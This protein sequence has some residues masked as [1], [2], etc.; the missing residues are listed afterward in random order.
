M[1]PN[2]DYF[3]QLKKHNPQL[4]QYYMRGIEIV[5]CLVAKTYQAF[6]VGGAVRD[7]L[8]NKE[9]KDIDIATS[10]T[11]KEL[12]EIF[13][14]AGTRYSEFGCI[15]INENGM[16]FQITTFR[17]EELVLTRQTKDIHYSKQLIDDVLR[18]DFTVNALALSANRNIVDILKGQKDIENKKV[19][20]IGDGKKRFKEDP[21]RILRGIE[22]ISRYNFSL[23]TSTSRAMKS[24]HKEIPNI[25]EQKLSELLW[26]ILNGNYAKKAVKTIYKLDLFKDLPVYREWFKQISKKYKYT[27]IEEKFALLYLMNQFIPSNTCFTHDQIQKYEN[28]INVSNIL[29]NVK[30]DEMVV[31]NYGE[32]LLISANQVL[33]SGKE[34]YKDQYKQIKKISTKLPIKDKKELKFSAPE[35]IQMMNGYTGPKIAEIMDRLLE[36]VVYGEV[37]NNNSLI[38]QEALKLLSE[39]E[40]KDKGKVDKVVATENML[41]THPLNK[42]DLP[43]TAVKEEEIENLKRAYILDFKHLFNIFMQDI[44]GYNEMDDSKKQEIVK[45]IRVKVK[46][47]ILATNSKYKILVEKGII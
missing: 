24:S 39:A 22:L 37:L 45:Q 29:K 41:S 10:A 31:F 27:N 8:L 21:L 1:A 18:R 32:S 16:I 47:S 2:N 38:R 44:P 40:N 28:I 17:D 13:P 23:T 5:E 19:R 42:N 26:N 43:D 3:V 20:V 9:F 46:E 6:I 36:K 15:E 7:Y 14:G 35:L 33:V 34:K 11:P 12:L 25:S 4:Y 30:V